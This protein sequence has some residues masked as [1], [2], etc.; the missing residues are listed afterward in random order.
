MGRVNIITGLDIGHDKLRMSAGELKDNGFNFLGASETDCS[1]GVKNGFIINMD[2]VS[3]AIIKLLED[4]SAKTN[5]RINSVFVNISGTQIRQE[6]A[7][8]VITLPQ[9]GYEITKRNIDDLIESCKIVSI[10]LDRHLLYLLPLE[11]VI[12]GQDGIKEPIGLCGSRLEAKV[13]IIT[14]PF[15]QI[16][17]IIKAVNSASLEVEE[18]VLSPLANGNSIVSREA[19]KEGVLLI[20][21]RTDLTEVAIFKNGDLVSFE[22][23][24]KGQEDITDEIAARFNISLESAEELKMKYGFLDISWQDSRNKEMIPLE[25]MGIRQDIVRGDLNRVISER[26]ELI[27][28]SVMK[29]IK[30]VKNI[31]TIIKKGAVLTGACV[32]M[33][34]FLEAAAQKF[35]IPVTAGVLENK[36]NPQGNSYITSLGLMKVGLEKIKTEKIRHRTGIFKTVYQKARALLTEYF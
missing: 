3:E 29:K 25:W 16:Q 10:P 30:G 15:N 32:S 22:T 8:S 2:S 31:K 7:N 33:E 36:E 27:F 13:L 1:N 35:G 18:V 19:K 24:A 4:I 26:L 9:R 11:Y 12:D 20:D 14:A 6:V 28:D 17:N 5:A 34:G 21:F 23:I